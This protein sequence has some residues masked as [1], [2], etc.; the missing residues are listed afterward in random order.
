MGNLSEFDKHSTGVHHYYLSALGDHAEPCILCLQRC[1]RLYYVVGTMG[2]LSEFDRH[3]TRD[4]LV[5]I[6]FGDHIFS[7]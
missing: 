2:N 3:S 1:K 7:V 5:F 4:R 6:R